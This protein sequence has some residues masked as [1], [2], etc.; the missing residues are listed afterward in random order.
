MSGRITRR[1]FLKGSAPTAAVAFAGPRILSARSPSEK[2]NVA[3][4]GTGGR[5]SSHVR[6]ASRQN[7]VA[8]VDV[9]EGRVAKAAKGFAK[10]AKKLLGL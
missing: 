9:D 5:G 7:V 8:L 1:K 6:A 2:V 10:H 4:I 3:V